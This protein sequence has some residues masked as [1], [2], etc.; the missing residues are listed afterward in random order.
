V[1]KDLCDRL[2]LAWGFGGERTHQRMPAGHMLDAVIGLQGAHYLISGNRDFNMFV[3]ML[4]QHGIELSERERAA[5]WAQASSEIAKPAIS[6][7]EVLDQ[8][9]GGYRLYW[10]NA[11]NLRAKVGELLALSTP[12]EEGD[13]DPR[14]WLVGVLRW[15]R[16]GEDDRLEAGVQLLTRKAEAIA[17]RAINESRNRVLHRGLLLQPLKHESSASVTLLTNTLLESTHSCE[18]LRAPDEFSFE[19]TPSVRPIEKLTQI[20]NSGSF[21]LFTFSEHADSSKPSAE[22]ESIWSTV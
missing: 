20:E 9:L 21:K 11:V 1:S 6:R 14:D 19:A 5:A 13:D 10:A 16:G 8:S 12:V 18:T 3:G 15:L 17:I 4:S 22:L 7:V 2:L